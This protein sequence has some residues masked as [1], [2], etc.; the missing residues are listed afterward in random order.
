MAAR[1]TWR[2][3]FWSTSIF[4]AVMIAVS[5][6]TFRETYGPFIL[7]KRAT[8]LRRE[9]GNPRHYTA[10][11]RLESQKSVLAI[12]SRVLTRPIRLLTFH[13]IIQVVA[14]I[15][16]FQYGILYIV[17]TSFSALWTDQYGEPVEIS[18]LHYLAVALGEIA[19]SRL[20]GPLMDILYRRMLARSADGEH[21]PEFRIPLTF[22]GSIL[23]PFG[24]VLYGW[25]AQYR[26]H[27]AVV[28]A[29]VFIMMFGGQIA[30]MPI[31]AYVMDAYPEHTS[32]ALAAQ[33][34]L[35]S[36]AAFL[37]PLF[38]PAMYNALGYGW[39]NSLLA[40][41]AFFFAVPAPGLLWIFGARLRKKMVSSY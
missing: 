36:M 26:L 31:S 16:A 23:V 10:T 13:P 3:M 39:G 4:Q 15:S 19:G 34:F 7:Q 12:L 11:E 27:W 24:L 35:R 40:F 29:G 41:A 2:W 38:V 9:T 17:L 32:S 25:A 28:D 21:V 22:L 30:G 14:L 18:G 20:G 8:R 1:T 5:F 6:T 33:Q 37:F